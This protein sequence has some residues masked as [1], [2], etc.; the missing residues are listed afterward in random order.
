MSLIGGIEFSWPTQIHQYAVVIWGVL[1]ALAGIF[2]KSIL[3][4][5][6]PERGIFSRLNE[7]EAES[8]ATFIGIILIVVG[9]FFIVFGFI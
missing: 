9:V 2:Y 3:R 4:I 7:D 1:F 5:T 6:K 8:L